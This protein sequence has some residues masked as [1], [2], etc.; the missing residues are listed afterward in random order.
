MPFIKGKAVRVVVKHQEQTIG[1]NAGKT[2]ANVA[3]FKASEVGG[4]M[5][6]KAD[7]SHVEID[8]SELPF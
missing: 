1:K 6:A 4:H 2:F 7:P 3:G 8:E 5:P